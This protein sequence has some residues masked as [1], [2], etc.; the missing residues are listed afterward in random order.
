MTDSANPP[1]RVLHYIDAV[2]EEAGGVV[3]CVIDLCAA[4]AHQG[5]EVTL[6]SYDTKDVPTKWQSEPVAPR[7]IDLSSSSEAWPSAV[8]ESNVVHLHTPWDRRN[9]GFAK[10]AC[11]A[12]KPYVVSIHGMLDDWSMDQ[13]PFKKRVYLWLAGK[14][15][16]ERAFRVHATAEGE[17]QQARKW[18]P[19]GESVVLPL[20]VDIPVPDELPGA[21]LARQT[22]PAMATDKPTVLFLSRL[23]PKKGVDLLIEAA[24]LL[25]HDSHA[26][27][28]I[29]AGSGEP[30][31][32]EALEEL[33]KVRGIAN[34]TH[35]VGLV[36][37]DLKLSLYQA[38]DLFV[39]PTHQE[40]F[41]LVLPEAMACGTP[42]VTTRGVDIWPELE[43]GGGVITENTPE[44]LAKEIATLL[45]DREA[46]VERGRRGQEYVRTWLDSHRVTQ[47]YVE[48]YRE[49]IAHAKW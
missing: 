34:H 24:A 37:G 39:L 32:V 11:D 48:L 43:A 36:T 7:V 29:I 19:R 17:V 44:V 41:G 23:H 47:G 49:T 45:G 5:C 20:V 27:E 25:H 4:L 6:A 46:L 16:L 22:F 1:V 30:A 26:F 21:E 28:L 8:R 40:N 15:M 3:R 14:K 12:H 10:V 18:Y 33:A 13:K 35:F 38:C 31:Y 9:A 42:V 2:R